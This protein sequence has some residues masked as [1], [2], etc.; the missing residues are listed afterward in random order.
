MKKNVRENLVEQLSS[1]RKLGVA[2]QNEN[3]VKKMKD[4]NHHHDHEKQTM[5]SKVVAKEMKTQSLT[6]ANDAVIWRVPRNKIRHLQPGFNLDYEPPK[7][8]PPIHN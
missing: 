3:Q 5:D 1:S 6:Y 4:H 2:D 7:T 8:N